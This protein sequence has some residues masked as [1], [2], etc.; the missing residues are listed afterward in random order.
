MIGTTSAPPSAF[1][2]AFAWARARALP[3]VP[4]R[5]GRLSHASLRRRLLIEGGDV[6]ALAGVGIGLGA[7]VEAEELAERADLEIGV[8]AIGRALQTHRRL[9]QESVGDRV[10]EHLDPLAVGRRQALP[11]G[12][13]LG[14]DL[15]DDRV[16]ALPQ[17]G[18]RRHHLLG[19]HPALEAAQLGVEDPAGAAGLRLAAGCVPLDDRLHLVDVVEADPLDLPALRIDVARDREVDEQQRRRV[20]LVHDQ[21]EL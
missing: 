10:G 15:R 14:E 12:R 4:R 21:L 20:A 5:S 19:A 2:T 17:S 6:R 3:R 11:A 18:D 9:V 7:G 16:G 13:V 1:A 8:L